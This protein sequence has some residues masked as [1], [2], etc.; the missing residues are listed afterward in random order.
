M[1]NIRALLAGLA[2]LLVD[3]FT[4]SL[5]TENFDLS[6][7]KV[8]VEGFFKI[9]YWGNTGAAWSLFYGYNNF[10]ALVSVLA[11]LL[12][13]FA[14]HHFEFHTVTGQ[15]ALGMM[16]GG[17]LGNLLDRIFT[18]HVIDFIYFYIQRRGGDEIGFPAFNFADIG[19]CTGVFLLFILALKSDRNEKTEST[20]TKE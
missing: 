11:L 18:K 10:L 20:G 4:K 9:V 3:R 15:I 19:I 5:I 2:V 8:I 16:C 6:G 12:I 1:P 14:R 13:I 17:I 7:Q